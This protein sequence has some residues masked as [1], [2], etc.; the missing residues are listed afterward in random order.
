MTNLPKAC[1][2]K[3]DMFALS[4]I[5]MERGSTMLK[6]VSMFAFA[7]LATQAQAGEAP[8]LDMS[9][10]LLKVSGLPLTAALNWTV[11][12]SADYSLNGGIIQGTAHMFVREATEQGY[13]LQQDIDAGIFGKQTVE[14]LY[15]KN[16]AM[17]L[18][19]IANGQD[20]PLP[21][22]NDTEIVETKQ[23]HITVPKGEFDCIY[24]KIHDKKQNQDAEIW[25]NPLEV[26]ISGM[27]KMMSPSQIGTIT[28][29]LT[30][31]M[32]K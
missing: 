11:G 22:P 25:A 16:T 10:P 17:P 8:K 13:W 21:D 30:D 19:I 24:A 31:F 3:I 7:L 29:E 6:I 28:L 9:R 18:K 12:D 2:I 27:L 15:D 26:P 1:R 4:L 20:Q 23:D 14:V 32:K 5:L